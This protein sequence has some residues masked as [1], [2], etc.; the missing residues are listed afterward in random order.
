MIEQRVTGYLARLE[1]ESRLVDRRFDELEAEIRVGELEQIL[2][3]LDGKD[4]E[5]PPLIDLREFE[6]AD[7]GSLEEDA[8][9]AV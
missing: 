8:P 2:G 3:T 9:R 6:P 5:R 4:G 1:T 7:L